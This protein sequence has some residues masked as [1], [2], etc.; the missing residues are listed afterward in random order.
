MR[1]AYGYELEFINL[2]ILL[3]EEITL[4]WPAMAA[5]IC[6]GGPVEDPAYISPIS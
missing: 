6:L 5:L 2:L 4:S 1:S 3:V